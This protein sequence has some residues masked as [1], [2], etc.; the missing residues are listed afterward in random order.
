MVLNRHELKGK[1]YAMIAARLVCLVY[2]SLHSMI[3]VTFVEGNE[4]LVLLVSMITTF[5]EYSSIY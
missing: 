4:V 2:C 3:C 1:N 5:S